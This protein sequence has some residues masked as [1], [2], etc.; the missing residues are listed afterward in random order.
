MYEWIYFLNI[1]LYYIISTIIYWLCTVF[2][3]SHLFISFSPF[4]LSLILFFSHEIFGSGFFRHLQVWNLHQVCLDCMHQYFLQNSLRM[5][6][7]EFYLLKL[8]LNY[9]CLKKPEPEISWMS[10]A[11]GVVK[12]KSNIFVIENNLGSLVLLVKS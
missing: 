1:K 3:L 10:Q 11:R 9:R 5:D 4:S 2:L 12:S 8:S 7:I 6:Y